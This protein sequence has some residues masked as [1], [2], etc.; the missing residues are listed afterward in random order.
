MRIGFFELSQVA[1]MTRGDFL[2]LFQATFDL[3]AL[4]AETKLKKTRTLGRRIL[5]AVLLLTV[6]AL[7]DAPALGECKVDKFAEFPVSR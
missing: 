7:F 4:N 5:A 3:A 1:L 6:S 2:R